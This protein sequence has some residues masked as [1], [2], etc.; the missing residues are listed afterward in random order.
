MATVAD[1]ATSQ[2][3]TALQSQ[4]P[5]QEG[6]EPFHGKPYLK[7]LDGLQ[8]SYP[9]LKSFLEKIANEDDKGRILVRKHFLTTYKRGPGRCYCLLF[10]HEKVS[11][12]EGFET[13]FASPTR[14]RDYLE[15]N[16][17]KKSREDKK[18]RLF[19][20]E[21]LEPDYVDALG[22]HLGVDPMV[23]SEQMNTW[24]Y[25]DSWS[26]PHRELPSMSTP[27]KCFTL[28]YY[29]LRTLHVPQSIDTLTLQMTFAVNRRRY[30]RWR[31]IDVPSSGKPDRRHGF[32]R[33]SASFWT[34][35]Q[36]S[37]GGQE[38][39]DAPGWDAV[40][41]VDPGMSVSCSDVPDAECSGGLRPAQR[42]DATGHDAT[43]HGDS[44][45]ASASSTSVSSAKPIDARNRTAVVE[46][47]CKM[48]TA[49]PSLMRPPSTGGAAAQIIDP[50]PQQ[51][52]ILQDQKLYSSRASLW[53]A[54][55]WQ[56]HG[57][58]VEL[59]GVKHESW[60]YH[61]GCSTLAPLGLAQVGV[62]AL[63]KDVGYLKRKRDLVSPL[64]EMVF[65]WTKVAPES[66]IKKAQAQSSNTAFY[67]LKHIAQHWVNQL[68]LINTTMAKAEWFSDD[69][70]AKIEDDLSLQKWKADLKDI[71]YIA[72][73]INYMRR[74]LNHFWRAMI[75]NLERV[76]VQLG[77]EGI[78]ENASLA[79]QGVQKDFLTIHTRMEP[80][81]SRAEALSTVASDLANLRAAYRGVHDSEFGMRLSL[82][83]SI[84]FPLTLVASIFSMSDNYLPGAPDFWKLWA[85]GPAFC[86]ALALLLVYGKR[87]WKLFTD[88]F[89]Y[90]Y[91]AARSRG[92]FL[93]PDE[94][95]MWL[96]ARE[97]QKKRKAKLK[98]QKAKEKEE[99]S[100]WK[101]EKA[102]KN[103]GR[104]K[105]DEEK[106]VEGV[107]A[108][109]G[110]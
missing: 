39:K 91:L 71:N 19:I 107:G 92:F 35:Q 81:R 59:V 105:R 98:A 64:D 77:S 89:K 73:D 37:E 28:R 50:P 9:A 17:A 8:H 7:G 80:L 109:K 67:L 72:K 104:G 95:E 45:V 47:A 5:A 30:E 2:D 4:V 55:D 85:I 65:Y 51:T 60:P 84:I 101:D 63:D 6:D 12:P 48:E 66:L 75:L 34:S 76:G 38:N 61:D 70:Q 96:N 87:P 52:L 56:P 90:F 20:L 3:G 68:E 53:R 32:V 18:R 43:A 58:R 83:A 41:L 102:T 78:D 103:V 29:E 88:I 46:A 13:G 21:D 40:I 26:I 1:S 86:V 108:G 24:N 57:T 82:F 11:L 16:P 54:Q 49:K 79:I 99:K 44:Q 31:D 93:S 106:E 42:H 10:D 36:P 27:E 100:R 33:R 14:L 110:K 94:K 69:Y 22:Y 15:A 23:F 62:G 25:T 97:E 74:H